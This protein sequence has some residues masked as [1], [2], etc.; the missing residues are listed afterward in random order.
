MECDIFLP[1]MLWVIGVIDSHGAIRSRETESGS[2]TDAERLSGRPW[3]WFVNSQDWGDKRTC[4]ESLSRDEATTVID[5]L[6]RSGYKKP[7]DFFDV[8]WANDMLTKRF[9]AVQ[10]GEDE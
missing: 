7:G 3:R 1:P 4:D 9:K 10:K 6:E 2:H 5:Y 8:R